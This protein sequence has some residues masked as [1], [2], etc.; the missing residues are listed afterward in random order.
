MSEK[1]TIK[2]TDV[3]FE[4]LLK[5]INTTNALK[6]QFDQA[7]AISINLFTVIAESNG[8]NSNDYIVERIDAVTKEIILT[9]KNTG[10]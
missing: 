5:S 7:D 4:I 2:V 6:K 3:T 8:M 9:K 10:K 1:T